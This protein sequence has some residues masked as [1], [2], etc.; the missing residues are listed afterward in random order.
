MTE[1]W[2]KILPLKSEES[3]TT[4]WLI[5]DVREAPKKRGDYPLGTYFVETTK[6]VKQHLSISH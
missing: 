1:K 6:T 4:M 2:Y 3:N 5:I